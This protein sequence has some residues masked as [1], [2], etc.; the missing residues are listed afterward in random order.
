[1]AAMPVPTWRRWRNATPA[2]NTPRRAELRLQVPAGSVGIGGRQTG[3]YPLSS[4]SDWQLIGHTPVALFTPHAASP[5]LLRPGDNV[6][7]V[8]QKEGVC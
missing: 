2:L 8:P 7:F 4:P 6:R 1:M 5:T 3:I